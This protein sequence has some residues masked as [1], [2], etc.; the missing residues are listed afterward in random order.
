MPDFSA[1]QQNFRGQCS[2]VCA[3]SHV[4]PIPYQVLCELYL[5]ILLK[6]HFYH[7][8]VGVDVEN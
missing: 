2:R 1:I 8:G 7:M 6:K 5:K 3:F 4:W